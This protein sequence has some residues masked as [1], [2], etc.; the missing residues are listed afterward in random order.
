MINGFKLRHYQQSAH[1]AALTKWGEDGY[2]NGE[3]DTFKSILISIPTGSGKTALASAIIDTLVSKNGGR[4]LFL[5]DQ[6]ELTTQPTKAIRKFTGIIPGLEK[7]EHRAS[8]MSDVIVGSLQTFDKPNRL[9]RYPRDFFTHIIQDESH[10]NCSRFQKVRDHFH[11]AKIAGLTAT[12]FRSGLKDLS[13]YFEDVAFNL[14]LYDLVDEGYLCGFKVDMVPLE[15][16]LTSVHQKRGIE[17]QDYSAEE[18]D[19]TIRPWY[20]AVAKEIVVRAPDKHIIAYL[21][22]IKSSKEFCEI[23]NDHG[24][25]SKHVDGKSKDREELLESFARGE[26]QCLCNSDLI[27]TGVDIPIA[28]CMVNLSPTRSAVRFRQR[29]G[30][31]SRVL[32]GLV[33]HLETAAER[34]AA[35]AV[36]S[37]PEALILDFLWQ[38]GEIGLQGPSGLVART[39]DE[40]DEIAKM[41]RKKRTPQQLEEIAATFKKQK[42]D[43]LKKQLEAVSRRK[44]Q[45][46]DARMLGVMIHASDII[47]FEPVSAWHSK[48]ISPGQEAFLQKNGIDP[49]SVNGRGHASQ[50]IDT[51]MKRKDSGLAS[52]ESVRLLQAA[53]RADADKVTAD[54]ADAILGDSTPFP[55]GKHRNRPFSKIPKGYWSWLEQQNWVQQSWPKVWEHIQKM[56]NE[57]F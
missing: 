8:L 34:K 17:G 39:E 23:L 18:L 16:D 56:K 43:D 28:D 45:V 19:D 1:D 21:P 2:W 36:S 29:A 51:L 24:V 27:S 3:S 10:R 22:L 32:P 46:I 41:L 48:P 44:G 35:I 37:K 5:G 57:P 42:E 38:T 49:T 20:E 15:I 50:I 6:D 13:K 11:T 12:P 26:F 33:D 52:L 14:H 40:A 7:A 54:E 25:S 30:R 55:F 4:C 53:G 31:I 9:S 47:E